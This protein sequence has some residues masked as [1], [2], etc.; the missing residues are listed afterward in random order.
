MSFFKKA[1][2]K[3]E[4]NK[5]SELSISKK[6]TVSIDM[7]EYCDTEEEDNNSDIFINQLKNI[8]KQKKK[9]NNEE[10][11]YKGP[12]KIQCFKMVFS[13]SGGCWFFI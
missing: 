2:S 9:K 4:R 13:F 12:T 7:S 1:L 5:Y 11:I 3:E 10:I 8:D 6:T